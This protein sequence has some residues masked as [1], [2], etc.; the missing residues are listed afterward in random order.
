MGLP[1]PVV[2]LLVVVALAAFGC[3]V[4]VSLLAFAS[5]GTFEYRLSGVQFPYV[6]CALLAFMAGPLGLLWLN[7][8]GEQFRGAEEMIYGSL[9]GVAAFGLMLSVV[10]VL[11]A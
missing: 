1:R 3:F 5:G 10:L 11:L 4:V 7:Y 8:R 6:A 2:A 9:F